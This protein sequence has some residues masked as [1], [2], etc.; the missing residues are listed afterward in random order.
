M[1]KIARSLTSSAY[2]GHVNDHDLPMGFFVR[3]YVASLATTPCTSSVVKVQKKKWGQCCA[4]PAAASCK[5]HLS[6]L[7]IKVVV[8]QFLHYFMLYS[9]VS[10]SFQACLEEQE[11]KAT[12]S[13]FSQRVMRDGLTSGSS[14]P[15]S[16]SPSLNTDFWLTTVFPELE[17]SVSEDTVQYGKI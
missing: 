3:S 11:I 9:F 5:W 17:S 2:K 7:Q 12:T 4:A 6:K 13:N 15:P 1:K 8:V 14:P 16:S 10:P